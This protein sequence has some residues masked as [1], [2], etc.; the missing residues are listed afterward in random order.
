[1][2]SGQFPASPSDLIKFSQIRD[3]QIMVT[4]AMYNIIDTT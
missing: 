2:H 1:M 3:I 4:F